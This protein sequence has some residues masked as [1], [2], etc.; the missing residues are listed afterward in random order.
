MIDL[1]NDLKDKSHI[2]CHESISNMAILVY[3]KSRKEENQLTRAMQLQYFQMWVV[4]A[5]IQISM[6]A[7]VTYLLRNDFGSDQAAN[8]VNPFVASKE[9]ILLIVKIL[10]SLVLHIMII[11][12]I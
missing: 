6:V 3:M 1:K 11:P 9:L 10:V 7:C 5:S 8:G 2:H 12:E 4:V